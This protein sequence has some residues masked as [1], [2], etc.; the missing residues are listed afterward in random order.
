MSK[1]TFSPLNLYGCLERV[2][3]HIIQTRRL[4]IAQGCFSDFAWSF[5]LPQVKTYKFL[6]AEIEKLEGD[7]SDNESTRHILLKRL[8]YSS[9]ANMNIGMKIRTLVKQ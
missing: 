5:P 2:K 8:L 3:I 4:K 7:I 1:A 6:T 9:K